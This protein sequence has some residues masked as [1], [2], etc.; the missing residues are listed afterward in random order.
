MPSEPVGAV[1]CWSSPDVGPL[2][3]AAQASISPGEGRISHSE[4]SLFPPCIWASPALEPLPVSGLE[5]SF[6]LGSLPTLACG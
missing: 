3:P 5:G 6:V 1:A 4:L 2:S